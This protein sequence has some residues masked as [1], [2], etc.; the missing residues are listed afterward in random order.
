[1]NPGE[2]NPRIDRL[3]AAQRPGWSLDRDFYTDPAVFAYEQE[4]LFSRHWIL[5]AHVDQVP[6]PGDYVLF[7]MA[8]ENVIIV[9]GRDGEIHAHYNV[10][11]H[12][13]SRVLLEPS[14]RIA[15]MTCRYHG[16]SYAL[17]GSLRSAA[18]MPADF[19]ADCFGLLACP[20]TVLEGLIFVCLAGTAPGGFEAVA[21][22]L[23]PFLRLQG[24]AGARI[25][26]RTVFA[27]RANWKL[28]VENYLECYHCKPAHREYCKV[29]IKAEKIGD[30][31]P[32]AMASYL[33]REREWRPLA[34]ALEALPPEFDSLLPRDASLPGVPFGAAYRAPLRK[35]HLTGSEDGRPVAP[36]MG[37]FQDYD[38]GETA[39]GIGPFTFM[40][41][42]NDYAALFQFVPRDV[43]RC[44]MIVT[45]L[46][47]G[48]AVANRDY[49]PE[50]VAWLW[51]V[52]SEQDKAIIEANAAGIRSAFYEPG[53]ASLLEADLVAFR[54][55]YLAVIGPPEQIGRLQPQGGGRY[56]GV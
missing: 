31:S 51:T 38:G 37:G 54:Q 41:A 48:E 10:C 56:F 9:R 12:R 4:R 29:E 36:L 1:V 11:R 44:D 27:V 35:T 13:G 14:G 42:Y 21:D 24:T 28:V 17:D 33:E 8:G 43:G 47:Q 52:T 16:W 30:G 7:D 49:D 22:G 25:A 45:W 40:L 5:A 23:R 19:Q 6:E 34:E 20:V 50:R 32:G 53:P 55:W 15:S 18:R 2:A 46:V 26:R 3:I 39:L